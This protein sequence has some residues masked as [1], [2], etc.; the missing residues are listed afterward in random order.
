[1]GID[2]KVSAVKDSKQRCQE[3]GSVEE[4]LNPGPQQVCCAKPSSPYTEVAGL[5][6]GVT[7]IPKTLLSEKFFLSGRGFFFF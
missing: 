4:I 6:T 7:A 5:V 3:N 1:M 2:K